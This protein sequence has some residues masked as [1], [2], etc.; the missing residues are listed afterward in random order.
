MNE[1]L[2]LAGLVA[3]ILVGSAVCSGV[4]A[5]MLTVNPLRVY[6]LAGRDRPVRGAKALLALK[7]RMGRALAVLV[8]LNNGFNIFGSLMLGS[9][10]GWVFASQGIDR[11]ALPLFSVG[12]TILVILLGEILPKA[13]GSRLALP[14]SLA[15]AAPLGLA[16]KLMLPLVLVLE[17]LLPAITAESELTTDEGEIRLLARLG[18]RTGQIEADE[19]AMIG[20]VFQLN[21]LTARDLM[22]PRVSA[23][24]LSAETQ[25]ESAKALLL[26]NTAAWWVVLGREVDEVL[27][28]AS[29]ESL[30]AAL[31]EGRGQATALSL[32]LPVEFVPEMIRADRLLTAF[33]RSSHSVR[34][35]VDEFG[36]FVGVIGADAVLA[37]LAGWWRRPQPAAEP[38][39]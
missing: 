34:V 18:S 15:S 1:L 10:A 5:A 11:V 2:G 3:F 35:V 6:E 30:L 12:L 38:I 36:G 4:E 22:V 33:R 26:A 37:V 8:I 9:Y 21:D 14:V 29:R 19:A 20:K 16:L 24:T 32:T 17:R 39:P 7:T 27:G 13:I 25:L 28:V 23:P 31:V